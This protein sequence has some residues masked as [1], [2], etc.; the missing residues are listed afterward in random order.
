[1]KIIAGLPAYNEQ[2]NIATIITK[3]KEFTDGVI[4]CND[5]SSD[6]TSQI[7]KQLGVIVVDHIKNLGYGSAIKSIFQRFLETDGD[8]LVT[9]DADGQHHAEDIQKIVKPI[10]DNN[11]D[12]VIGSRFTE[13]NMTKIPRYRK[14]GI[15]AITKIT[16]ISTKQKIT[17]SQSGFRAYRR[18]IILQTSLSETGMAVSTE[19]L[20]KADR[21]N[22]RI[23]EVGITVDYPEDSSTHN[24]VSHGTSVFIKTLKFISIQHPLK[25]F[26]ISAIVFLC[27]GI[28]FIIWTIQAYAQDGKIITNIALIG[29]GITIVGVVLIQTAVL[30]HSIISIMKERNSL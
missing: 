29:I 12:L 5:G 22:F 21:K 4:V 6:L 13:T 17:D 27:I 1:M 16:N 9:I 23:A 10:I 25:F 18:E 14:F 2:S 30:L 24:P 15:S 26:G 19:I 8:I 28:G 11:A 3:L 7:A 20:I